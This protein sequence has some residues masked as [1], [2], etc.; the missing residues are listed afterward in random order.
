MSSLFNLVAVRRTFELVK[1]IA[2]VVILP[3]F[4]IPLVR[5]SPLLLPFVTR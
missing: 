2:E 4:G 5:P 3:V 1:K